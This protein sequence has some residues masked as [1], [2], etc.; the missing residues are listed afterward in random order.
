MRFAGRKRGRWGHPMRPTADGA[1]TRGLVEGRRPDDVGKRRVGAMPPIGAR[2]DP[3]EDPKEGQE[4]DPL[5][6]GSDDPP[7]PASAARRRAA[8][9][10]AFLF[11]IVIVGFLVWF[12]SRNTERSEGGTFFGWREEQTGD[13]PSSA[14][15]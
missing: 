8:I 7:P 1:R 13:Y 2:P 10:V 14:V 3:W 15:C 12:I 11:I 6:S 4:G 9:G 5:A